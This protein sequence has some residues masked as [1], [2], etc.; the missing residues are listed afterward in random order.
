MQ[1]DIKTL[2]F[3][4]DCLCLFGR[5]SLRCATLA[6]SRDK[7]MAA[8]AVSRLVDAR[9]AL[10]GCAGPPK[11]SGWFQSLPMSFSRHEGLNL[12]SGTH[13]R[14]GYKLWLLS[15]EPSGLSSSNLLP[16]LTRA[17]HLAEWAQ[18]P[19]F[20]RPVCNSED[21]MGEDSLIFTLERV[22]KI[23]SDSHR[24][25]TECATPPRTQHQFCI[26]I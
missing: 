1:S 24:I 16:P 6:M 11:Q 18:E 9:V 3:R 21:D 17:K 2:Q 19:P 25:V 13:Q 26:S 10:A 12:R 5:P 23:T 15:P 22:P 14:I 8:P 7:Q 20:G 4:A